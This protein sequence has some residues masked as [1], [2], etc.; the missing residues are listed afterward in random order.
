VVRVV[1]D[2]TGPNT[3]VDPDGVIVTAYGLAPDG[4]ALIRPD[5]YLGFVPDTAD[6]EVLPHYLA[7]HLHLTKAAG[8][9]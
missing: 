4:V 9:R 2:G 5:G 1:P 7:D 3:L 8:V 6:P